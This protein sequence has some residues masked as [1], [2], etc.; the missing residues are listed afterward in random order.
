MKRSFPSGFE[1]LARQP[2]TR[3]GTRSI[4]SRKSTDRRVELYDTLIVSSNLEDGSS[5]SSPLRSASSKILVSASSGRNAERGVA[6]VITLI[7]LSII[8][9]VTVA[10]LALSQR[11]RAAVGQSTQQTI[12]EMA[13]ETG[14]ERATA[15]I[16]SRVLNTNADQSALGP[17]LMVSL[18]E[19]N[20]LNQLWPDPWVPV[21]VT[22]RAAPLG[23]DRSYLDLNRNRRFDPSGDFDDQGNPRPDTVAPGTPPYQHYLGD[24]MWIGVLE[25][26]DRPHSADNRFIARYCFLVVPAGR[27][28]D[29]NYVHNSTLETNLNNNFIGFFR[30]QGFGTWEINLAGFLADLNTNANMWGSYNFIP[31]PAGRSAGAAFDDARDILKYRYTPLGQA[32][33]WPP[34]TALQALPDLL[35]APSFGNDFIDSFG[36]HPWVPLGRYYTNDP[37]L[38][39]GPWPAAANLAWSGSGDLRH[40]FSVH[41]YFTLGNKGLSSFTSKLGLASQQPDSYDRYTFYRL[42]AQVSTDTASQDKPADEG[43]INLNYA[44]VRTNAAGQIET[45]TGLGTNFNAWDPQTFFLVTADKLL[46]NE[47]LRYPTN[48]PFY[49]TNLGLINGRRIPIFTNGSSLAFSPFAWGRTNQPLYSPRIHQLLQLAANISEA[50]QRDKVGETEP[51]FPAVFRPQFY[52]EPTGDIFIVGYTNDPSPTFRN[53]R[54]HDLD[55]PFATNSVGKVAKDDNIYGI[56]LIIG[57]RKGFPNFNEVAMLSAVQVTRK[58]EFRKL[59][60][61][62]SPVET[63]QMFIIGVSNQF[64]V[65]AWN[66]YSNT[67]KPYPR[68]LRMEVGMTTQALL[69]NDAGLVVNSNFVSAIPVTNIVG[70]T[71][72][73]QKFAVSP[74]QHQITLA[75]SVFYTTPTPRLVPVTATTAFERSQSSYTYIWG[76]T[77]RSKLLFF[78]IDTG[79]TPNRIVDA[80]SLSGLESRFDVSEELSKTR[81]NTANKQKDDFWDLTPWRN[82]TQGVRRQI[83]VSA[84]IED[85]GADWSSYGGQDP[86]TGNDKAKAIDAFRIF[87]NVGLSPLVYTDLSQLPPPTLVMQ[88]PFQ[89]VKRMLQTTTWEVNDPLVHYTLADLRD[90]TNNSTV[91]TIDPNTPVSLT[92]RLLGKVN[93][94]Y[95]PWGKTMTANEDEPDDSAIK[96]PGVFSSDYWEF[97]QQKLP[98]V[99]WLGRIHRGTPWQTI[100]FKAKPAG[101]EGGVETWLR[102][103]GGP[104]WT[105]ETHP[106]NDWRL[107]DLFTTA[108]NDLAARGRLSVNQTNL[109]AW[110]A[111]FSG[112]GVA[113]LFPSNTAIGEIAMPEDEVFQPAATD[114]KAFAAGV[115]PALAQIVEGI[116]R[117]RDRMP[118]RMFRSVGELLSTPELTDES[119]FLKPPYTPPD[120]AL[121]KFIAKDSAMTDLEMERIPAQMLSLVTVGEPRFVIYAWGQSL[122]PAPYG[123]QYDNNGFI[124]PGAQGYPIIEPNSIITVASGNLFRFCGNYQVTAEV[125]TRTVLRIDMDPN[126]LDAS[127]TPPDPRS[128]VRPRAVIESFNILPNE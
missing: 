71:W 114:G 43:K 33:P 69:T 109:A 88:A 101:P 35:V 72:A 16:I 41:D 61:D 1:G 126:R 36:T 127:I 86:S 29:L 79:V 10:F 92:Q 87:L 124:R 105:M 85:V 8:T 64:G 58:L 121:R 99:G 49:S 31:D 107:V 51:F 74:I 83:A 28:L 78:L 95:R 6:L 2:F 84:G 34:R 90:A 67:S 63:N 123:V 14:R 15:Q 81:L 102:A 50:T 56:P 9:V 5:H 89:P 40:F 46:T 120:M 55:D 22:N 113:S 59:T 52:R 66:S 115:P 44:N 38:S 98:N 23:E 75:N 11:E 54:W 24:P 100:Y 108:P 111:V 97:P 68:S 53:N 117:Q 19:S 118:N 73:G 57:A 76:L 77:V 106:T 27:T 18:A 62:G 32:L 80:V 70:G 7:M 37:D 112:I 103:G 13:A 3:A 125:A 104:A 60:L 12:A 30:N 91:L 93:D 42:L 39:I 47:F 65:E 119:P 96:D 48:H 4:A 94:R 20:A 25:H 26:P 82:A 21:Y 128:F 116:N 110:S 17:D 45:V 122:Q